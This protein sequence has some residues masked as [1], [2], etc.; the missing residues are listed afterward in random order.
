MVGKHNATRRSPIKLKRKI[1]HCHL[2][3]KLHM[4]ENKIIIPLGCFS[5]ISP[6]STPLQNEPVTPVY[7]IVTQSGP[8]RAVN[9]TL[10]VRGSVRHDQTR[11]TA[12]RKL[13]E[14]DLEENPE[15]KLPIRIFSQPLY[16]PNAS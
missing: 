3:N 5:Q 11:H 15:V 13:F 7:T 2:Q 4:E 16:Q 10:C 12:A 9:V 8:V 14:D 6:L 1:H